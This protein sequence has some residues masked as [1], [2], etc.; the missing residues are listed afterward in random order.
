MPDDDRMDRRTFGGYLAATS[1]AA[2]ATVLSLPLV[3][4]AND[5]Q[6]DAEQQDKPNGEANPDS[7]PVLPAAPSQELL[8]LTYLTHRYPSKNF[9][10]AALEGIVRDIRGDLARGRILSEFPLQ[11][12]DEPSF[13]FR[14]YRDAE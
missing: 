9:D 14:A 10:D 12:S 2:A 8:M 3:G 11:N 7:K 1:T 13:A 6:A 5:K 4:V